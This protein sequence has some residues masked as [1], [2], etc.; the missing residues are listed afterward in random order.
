MIVFIF[1]HCSR[2]QSG[3]IQFRST[4]EDEL[5]DSSESEDE[6]GLGGSDND[7]GAAGGIMNVV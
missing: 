5:D 4:E 6:Q 3:G 1:T 7:G 2:R